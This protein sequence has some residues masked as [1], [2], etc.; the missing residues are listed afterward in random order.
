MKLSSFITN[1]KLVFIDGEAQVVGNDNV[2]NGEINFYQPTVEQLLELK[3]RYDMIENL[4]E[5][6]FV[7]EMI[8]YMC[9]VERDISLDKFVNLFKNPNKSFA[10]FL[11]LFMKQLTDYIDTAS[12]LT[13]VETDISK[14]SDKLGIDIPKEKIETKEEKR[15]R[16]YEEFKL[17]KSVQDRNRILKEITELGE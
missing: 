15:E 4:G 14:V 7:Y 8:G 1:K 13:R 11:E 9:D 16:L 2:L 3:D 5:E 10:L 6:A 12:T 17:A